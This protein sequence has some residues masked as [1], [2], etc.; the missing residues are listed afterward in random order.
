MP[1]EWEP[2]AATW[3]G[4]PHNRTDWPGK[5]DAIPWVYAEM[6]RHLVAGERVDIL[7][8]SGAAKRG[9]LD[10]LRRAHV[11]LANLRFHPWPTNRGWTRDFAPLFV[12]R[13]RSGAARVRRLP[14]VTPASDRKSVV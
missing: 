2:H 10:V 13:K 11:P 8:Q 1:A 12:S 9:A 5:F 3:I 7:V 6:V 4:W 14:G